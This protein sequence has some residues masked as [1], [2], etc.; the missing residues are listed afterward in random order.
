MEDSWYFINSLLCKSDFLSATK[1][2]LSSLKKQKNNYSATSDRWEYTKSHL[3][4]NVTRFSKNFTTQEN[5]RISILEERLR[6]L[7][8]QENFKP[9]SK[10]MIE[11]LPEE[12]Y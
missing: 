3:K 9:E 5:I 8:K 6:N 4:K 10:P 12:L 11:N 2:L 7:Y 1:E